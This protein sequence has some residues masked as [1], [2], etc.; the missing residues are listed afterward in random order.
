[1]SSILISWPSETLALS[2]CFPS[3]KLGPVDALDL[4]SKGFNRPQFPLKD[5]TMLSS[6]PSHSFPLFLTLFQEGFTIIDNLVMNNIFQS[7]RVL[8]CRLAGDSL[9][10]IDPRNSFGMDIIFYGSWA[11]RPPGLV[12]KR[13]WHHNMA[14]YSKVIDMSNQ[15]RL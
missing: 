1:M 13:C 7:T 5:P 8:W 15:P 4:S 14:A 3:S 12:L 6:L 2:R 10:T 11:C 9:G